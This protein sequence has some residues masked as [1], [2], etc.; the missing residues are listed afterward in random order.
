M[1]NYLG[2][3]KAS[4]RLQHAIEHVYAEG[5]HLTRDVGGQASTTQFTDAVIRAVEGES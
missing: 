5:R 1:L 2:E 4:Q 3:K